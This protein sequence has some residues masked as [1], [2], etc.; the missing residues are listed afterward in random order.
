MGVR[1]CRRSCA[2]HAIAA[3]RTVNWLVNGFIIAYT[4]IVM[5]V[6]L[7]VPAPAIPL[8][9]SLDPVWPGLTLCV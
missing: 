4:I 7:Q 3:R 9:T 8:A 1:A 6:I 2:A 5:W